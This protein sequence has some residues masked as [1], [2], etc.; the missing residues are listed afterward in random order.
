MQKRFI[1]FLALSAAILLGWQFAVQKFFPQLG[2]PKKPVESVATS[3]PAPS[4][5]QP[6]SAATPAFPE[7]AATQ[8]SAELTRE[9]RVRT[10]FWEGRL[11][12]HG[13]VLTE[14]KVTRFTD[15]KLVDAKSGGVTLVSSK[16]SQEV[17]A[18]FRLYIP[19]DRQLEEEINSARFVV[20]GPAVD[21]VTIAKNEQKEVSFLYSNNGVTARKRLTFDGLGYDFAIQADVTRNGQP[22]ETYLVVGPNF[23]DQGI[24]VHSTYRPAPQVSYS[25]GTKVSREHA[26]SVNG[27][28]QLIQASPMRWASVDDNYFAMAVVPAK[29]AGAVALFNI[30]KMEDEGGKQVERNYV[31]VAIP[32]PAGEKNYVY[33]GPKDLTT[34]TRISEKFGLGDGSGNLE[35]IVNYGW[36]SFISFII[37][38]LSHFMLNSLLFING[39]THNYGWA[40]VVLTVV[41]NMF[42]FP[43]RWRSSVAMRRTAAMQPKMKDLQERMK[44]LDKNDPRMAE[45]QKEQVALMREGNPLMGCLPLLLQM[46]FFLAVY[47]ILTVSIEVRHAPFVGWITDLSAPDPFWILPIVMCI[48]MI[49]QQALTPTTGDPMQKRMGYL[50]PLIFAYFLTG[51]PAGLVLYWMMSNLVGIGQ[52]FVINKLNPPPP[53]ATA[54]QS[55]KRAPISKVSKGPKGTKAKTELASS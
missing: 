54:N 27:S 32:I 37:K 30:K 13:A 5:Q 46:P 44:K 15:G 31:S 36:L 42:F 45:L 8:A 41:L 22:I 24:T 11:T 17:G 2:P 25:V 16:V 10:E 29:A 50:M 34:L 39:F 35:D 9:I 38:P 33:A 52:Q 1:L 12:N 3:S 7:K 43:L 47:T 26:T 14:W 51:A 23:G 6:A 20:E 18:P 53:T 40:I 49:V 19:S 4:A 55:D 21:D 28:P 48:S